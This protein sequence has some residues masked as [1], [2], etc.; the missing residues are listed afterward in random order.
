MP[1]TVL[2]NK[3][4]HLAKN[5]LGL[6]DDIYR[7]ILWANFKVASSTKLSPFQADKLLDIFKAKGWKAKASKDKGHSP[8]YDNPQQR[9]VVAMWIHL[10]DAKVIRNRNDFALQKYVKRVTGID[11]L[12]WCSGSECFSLI[13]SLKAMGKR[14][15]VAFD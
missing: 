7:D 3:K 10:A 2:Q 12:K 5:Q 11:N 1:P 4:I 9:K 6:S 8:K 15:S 14:K 13:E